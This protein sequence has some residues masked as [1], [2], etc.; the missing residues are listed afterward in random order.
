MDFLKG[1]L[2]NLSN[3][4]GNPKGTLGD[5]QHGARLYVDDSFRLAP[6]QKFLYHVT[7][8]INR[9]ASNIIP[10]LKEKHSNELNML[11]KNADLPSYNIDTE[12]KNQYN[13][14]KV[15]QRRIDY[16]PIRI[17][18]HDDNFGVTTAM[19]EAYYRYYFK[20]GNYTNVDNAGNPITNVAAYNSG[21]T[22]A[23]ETANSFRYGFD[24]DSFQPFFDSI[25]I[26]QMSRKRYTSFT[27]VNPKISSWSHDTMDQS[28]SD[29]VENAMEL[30]YETVLYARGPVT[31]GSAPKGFA[32]EHYD[33]SPSPISIAGGGTTSLLGTGGVLAGG[34]D[35]LDDITSG[36]AFTSPGALLGTVLRARNTIR[37]GGNLSSEGLRQEGYGLLTGALGAV[38]AGSTLSGVANSVFPKSGGLGTIVT[39]G[40]SSAGSALT[41]QNLQDF[42][43]QAQASDNVADDLAKS[44]TFLKEHLANGGAADPESVN[45]A[46]NSQSNEQKQKSREAARSNI[47]NLR[48]A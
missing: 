1:F 39:Q 43:Q 48:S 37:Q 20:D 9:S 22:Y 47:S 12:V 46:Y 44:T 36:A 27:L 23:G 10:Q 7:F 26:Y 30:Q 45:N 35:V 16:N 4:A 33:K 3:G 2:D 42:A 6:K 25:V 14:K 24:N 40:N 21:N 32:T 8:N 28:S 5:W 17:T 31:E 34:L 38:A 29:P 11:V 15:I 18:F 19:W 13:R 41:F